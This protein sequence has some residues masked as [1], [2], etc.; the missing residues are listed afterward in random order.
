[1]KALIKFHA[2]YFLLHLFKSFI[3]F[4]SID[5]ET[6]K[7]QRHGNRP[8]TEVS[9]PQNT[10]LK[11]NEFRFRAGDDEGNLG[12]RHTGAGYLLVQQMK[13]K[14]K[15]YPKNSEPP[16]TPAVGM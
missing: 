12:R 4:Y 10:K 7:T 2:N 5:N 15:V 16:A 9:A 6:P 1:L 14:N 11:P 8:T 13:L 3:S